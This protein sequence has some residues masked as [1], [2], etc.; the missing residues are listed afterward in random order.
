MT[1]TQQDKMTDGQPA[2]TRPRMSFG[3]TAPPAPTKPPSSVSA[4][5]ATAAALVEA[6]PPARPGVAPSRQGKKGVTFYLTT[7]GWKELRN[8][9]M[10]EDRSTADL[11]VEATNL[12]LEKYGRPRIAQG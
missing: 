9:S 2:R 1:R 10:D 12:L 4:E 7:P 6:S 5:T 3:V 11:M 8:L